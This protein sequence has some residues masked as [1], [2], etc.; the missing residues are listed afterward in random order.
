MTGRPLIHNLRLGHCAGR[1]EQ[2]AKIGS[3]PGVWR[4]TL[5]LAAKYTANL[6]SGG[7]CTLPKA[8]A[9]GTNNGDYIIKNVP[10]DKLREVIQQV[11][12]ALLSRAD[13]KQERQITWWAV[14]RCTA[15]EFRLQ[16]RA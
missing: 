1:P 11:A 5:F 12:T 16:L 6:A 7:T 9:R 8:I 4:D 15:R 3:P 10:K 14:P 13:L 2:A